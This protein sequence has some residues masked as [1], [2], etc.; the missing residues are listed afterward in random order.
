M[1]ARLR[2]IDVLQTGSLWERR[3][4]FLLK[5]RTIAFV[6][7]SCHTVVAAPA[8][9]CICFPFAF[10]CL[11]YLVDFIFST[12]SHQKVSI[13]AKQCLAP[14]LCDARHTQIQCQLQGTPKLA[15]RCPLLGQHQEPGKPCL[16]T[17]HGRQS[18]MHI[19]HQH[20]ADEVTL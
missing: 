17:K 3:F 5:G 1:H 10:H 14:L 6:S 9:I 2:V 20:S 19:F 12:V 15:R 11:Q 18:K 13:P 7:T 4:L 16:W 8:R